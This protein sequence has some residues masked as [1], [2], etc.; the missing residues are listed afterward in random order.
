LLQKM[1]IVLNPIKV[2]EN[3]QDSKQ[4]ELYS[5]FKQ[6]KRETLFVFLFIQQ[7]VPADNTA[8]ERTIRN[9]TVKQKKLE[10]FKKAKTVQNFAQIRSVISDRYHH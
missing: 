8:S 6:I 5:F 10:Q 1:K 4:K 2:F 3:I 9:V 7:S